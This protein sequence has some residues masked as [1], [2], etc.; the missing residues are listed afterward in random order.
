MVSRGGRVVVDGTLRSES[1]RRAFLDRA[2]ALGVP[3]RLLVA[4][5]PEA[6]IRRR[7]AA[8][9]P[10]WSDADEGV[11]DLVAARWEAPGHDTARDTIT[12]DTAPPEAGVLR[13]ALAALV[14]EGLASPEA[15]PRDSRRGGRSPAAKA[16][17]R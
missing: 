9:P 12:V 8:R 17:G 15:A 13:W 14:R 2:T 5:A 1:R 4:T 6:T 16:P 3:A 11:Y 7:L 10:G